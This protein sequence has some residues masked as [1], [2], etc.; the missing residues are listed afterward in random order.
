MGAEPTAGYAGLA[1]SQATL[2]SKSYFAADAYAEDLKAI[3]HRGWIFACRAAELPEPRAYRVVAL[4]GQEI[5]I[6]RDEEGR[7]NAFH[8]SCRHRGSQL[9]SQERGRLKARLITCPY[10]AW[11]Y[12]L[13]GRLVRVPVQRLPAGFDR[14][15]FPLYRVALAEWRGFVFVSLTAQPPPFAEALDAGAA[16]LAN[17]PIEQLAVGASW[18]KTMACNWKIFWENFN[19][20]LHCPGVHPRLSRL[21]PIYGRGLMARHDDPDWARNADN[22]EPEY[23]GTLRHGAVSWSDDGRAHAPPFAGLSAAERQAGQTYAV[24]LPSLFVVGHVD[25]VRTV[26]VNPLGPEQTELTAEWLFQPEALAPGA[27]DLDRIVGFGRQVMEEDAAVCELNQR[28]LHAVAHDRGVLMPE[29]YELK[30]FH[31]WVRDAHQAAAAAVKASA[32][33]SAR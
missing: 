28:G 14:A 15:E 13:S 9:C 16:A 25:Y 29:E 3:W 19:E 26:R 2:P 8:N 18:R 31:D 33:D 21:V 30:R 22:D 24:S 27:A 4:A 20:C 12:S 10:H 7:L 32:A 1:R 11:S 23:A 6:V 5:L 17:W